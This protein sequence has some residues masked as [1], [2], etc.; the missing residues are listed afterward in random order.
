SHPARAPGAARRGQPVGQRTRPAA[1]YVVAGSHE[2][3]RGALRR[4]VDRAQENRPNGGVRAGRNA[5][6]AGRGLAQ[7]L[8]AL[9]VR[10]ARPS[11]RFCRGGCMSTVLAT[12]PS[13]ALKRRINAAPSKI[14]QALTDPEKMMRG[15]APAGTRALRA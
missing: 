9:L 13:L 5:D 7:P 10:T 3:P 12:K 14:Y 6:G 15:D 4:R 1:S 8:P 2:A 11:R